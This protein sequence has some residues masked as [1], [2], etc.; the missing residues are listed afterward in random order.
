MATFIRSRWDS[1]GDGI[2]NKL[3]P[4]PYSADPGW[5]PRAY[6]PATDPDGN[7][8]PASCDT[9]GS[10]SSD[11]DGDGFQNRFDNCPLVANPDQKDTD[12]DGIGDA[13]DHFPLDPTDGGTA[14]RD[15]ACLAASIQIGAG[16]PAAD[17]P[18]CPTGP[19]VPVP[20]TLSVF[21]PDT[22][23]PVGRMYSLN[24]SVTDPVTQIGVSAVTVNF[25]ITG[26]N[27]GSGNCLTGGGGSCQFSY[28]GTKPGQDSILATASANG[29]DL[30]RTVTAN[31]VTPPAN[32]DFA[33]AAVVD[34][35]PFSATPQM[36][37]SDN[38]PGEPTQ[39]GPGT[40][41]WYKLTPQKHV[42]LR[43]E[44]EVYGG[45]AVPSVY[46]GTSIDGLKLLA[47]TNEG[48]GDST[49][50]PGVYDGPMHDYYSFAELD[51]GQTYYVRVSAFLYN[52]GGG[53]H[54][55]LVATSEGDTNCDGVTDGLD[56]L[57]DLQ[58]AAHATVAGALLP[59][60]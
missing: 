39:C 40:S 26:A 11:V 33:N 29:Q 27:P 60:W 51:A 18:V 30:N 50:Y 12:G 44:T 14:H 47:C 10:S 2:E 21:P 22:T 34:S 13:C 53:V 1:D 54:L 55:D 28:T 5:D 4:C 9:S 31:W 42:F 17:P 57:A 52:S 6:S 15:E 25:Q 16:G 49:P 48:F 38:Q 24:A 45:I 19:D 59:G 3:D 35:L 23:L 43:A 41:V 36:A 37:G 8:I 56:A 20:L 32:N 46:S 58:A 7:G